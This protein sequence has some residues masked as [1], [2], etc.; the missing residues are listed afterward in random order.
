MNYQIA[1]PVGDEVQHQNDENP[2][3]IA[4]RQIDRASELL[5]LP[6]SARQLL[7]YPLREFHFLL[8]VKMDDG[9]NTIFPATA[10]SGTMRAGPGK[11]GIRF[12]P[13]ETV[14]TVRALAAWMTLKT[15]TLDL[16]VGRRQGRRDLRPQARSR[17]LNWSA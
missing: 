2:L 17:N 8:S 10:S 11:G 7:R 5:D 3:H 14:D 12:H 15:A 1:L 4:Q 6:R 13:Q 16:P 9:S